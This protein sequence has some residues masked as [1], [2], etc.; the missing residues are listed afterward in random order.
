MNDKK[1]LNIGNNGN[2]QNIQAETISDS[3]IVQGST[4]YRSVEEL[5]KQVKSETSK[6]DEDIREI[7]SSALQRIEKEI[8]KPK[9]DA[10]KLKSLIEVVSKFVPIAAELLKLLL[11]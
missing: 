5:L 1:I 3:T 2:I 4:E 7:C 8:R 6:L 10:E 11:K 9:R